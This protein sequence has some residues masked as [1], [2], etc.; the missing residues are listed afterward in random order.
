MPKLRRSSRA[1]RGQHSRFSRVDEISISLGKP[2]PPS[3]EVASKQADEDPN[4]EVSCVCKIT[5]EDDE[6]L[7]AQCEMCD[8]WQHV[9][10]LFGEED[11]SLLPEKYYCHICEPGLYPNLP[12]STHTVINTPKDS[13]V[14]TDESNTQVSSNS[15]NTE[16]SL[17]EVDKPEPDSPPSK[18][19][20]VSPV[21][22]FLS[23]PLSS[24]SLC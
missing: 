6:Q 2:D 15:I 9:K 1:T 13:P 17:V 24:F 20:K 11:D 16:H 7:M 18:K 22:S 10:C 5:Y 3:S 21:S 12:S 23:L 4:S 19:R 8:K 14:P